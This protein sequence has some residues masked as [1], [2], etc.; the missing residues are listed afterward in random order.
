MPKKKSGKKRKAPSKIKKVKKQISTAKKKQS[1]PN[2]SKTKQNNPKQTKKQIIRISREATAIQQTMHDEH[3]I[4]E[5]LQ[6][7]V[8]WTSMA[9]LIL[10]NFLGAILLVPFLL[11]FTGAA[12]YVLILLFAI[13]LGLLF[14]LMIHSI[15][16]LGDKHHLI[17][18][19]V[20]PIFALVDVAILF[21]IL[22]A[23]KEALDL[24][25]EYNYTA[26]VILFIAAFLVPYIFDILRK[27]HTF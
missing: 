8:S 19:I 3:I 4:E 16:H 26:I 21:G 7:F 1:A 2:R 25:T 27:K 6:R 13:G 24:S 20:I 17:A 9:L 14:N 22:E 12:Q 15:E 11:F 5:K 18:G 23:A 10:T